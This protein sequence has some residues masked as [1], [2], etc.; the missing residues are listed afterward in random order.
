MEMTLK[1]SPRD[2]FLH[3]LA[4]VTL[5]IA[6]VSFGT[7]LFQYVNYFFPDPLN[8]P[9]GGASSAVRWALASL[10]IVFPVYVWISWFLG[11]DAARE[12]AKRELRI[13]KWLLYFTLFLAAVVM[14]TDL[15]ALIY[16]F[17]GGELSARFM[18]KVLAVLSIA[19]AVFVY[20]FWNLR[21]D[22]MA[23][24]DALMRFFMWGIVVIVAAATVGG[25]FLA[26]SPFAERM[27]RFDERRAGDLQTIQWQ[28]VSYWQ[29]K[30]KLPA[31]L[32][33][34]RDPISGF[35]LPSDPETG[36]GYEYRAVD[37]LTFELCATFRTD[38]AKTQITYAKEAVPP[39]APAEI[40]YRAE[41]NWRHGIGRVCFERTIDPE[42]YPPVKAPR[43]S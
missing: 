19:A 9:I 30:E 12:P 8:D 42:F 20:Y 28:I 36:T 15:V 23:S 6:A 24:R 37:R 38:S 34:L 27:R 35:V 32:D 4:I 11:R 3:L 13:R 40:P 1:S 2:V 18:L 16:T 17:L 26:G 25:F 31:T 5:Y 43:P 21:H 39:A 33:D 29:S 10:V 7:L 14:I 22:A 41:D